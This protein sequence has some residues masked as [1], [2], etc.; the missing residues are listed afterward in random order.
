MI[1]HISGFCNDIIR[2]FSVET[3][4]NVQSL[5]RGVRFKITCTCGCVFVTCNLIY[6]YFQLKDSDAGVGIV[7]LSD[8]FDM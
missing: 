2:F 7:V 1:L 4:E 5:I 8:S 6:I 3:E